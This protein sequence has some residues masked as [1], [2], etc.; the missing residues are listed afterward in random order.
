[1]YANFDVRRSNLFCDRRFLT[2]V[3]GKSLDPCLP[4]ARRERGDDRSQRNSGRC[5][6]PA[7]RG[8]HVHVGLRADG[9]CLG[10]VRFGRLV[11]SVGFGS[12]RVVLQCW[13]GVVWCGVV[14][15]DLVWFGSSLHASTLQQGSIPG[16]IHLHRY[17]P[18]SAAA[19]TP[20]SRVFLF[21]PPM[22]MFRCHSALGPTFKWWSTR[23]RR[24]T[25]RRTHSTRAA[26][27]PPPPE[28]TTTTALQAACRSRRRPKPGNTRRCS[29][30][31]S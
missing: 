16:E 11:A 21:S 5:R 19:P 13:C 9:W 15:F 3:S 14:W 27:T 18:E 23:T 28:A 20:P 25:R 6:N 31:L 24:S 7:Q 17:N 30:G 22:I 26:A 4:D 1:M 2:G 10:S 29:A 8:V 12:V